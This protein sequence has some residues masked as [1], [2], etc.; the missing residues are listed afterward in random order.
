MDGDPQLWGTGP[1]PVETC[2]IIVVNPA[3]GRYGSVMAEVRTG[4]RRDPMRLRVEGLA[5]DQMA[6]TLG[7]FIPLIVKAHYV[8]APTL[9]RHF[10]AVHNALGL[11]GRQ[12]K[13]TGA[14]QR[15]RRIAP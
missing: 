14:G 1:G 7:Y 5:A 15:N 12:V 4:M 8:N 9:R 6:S 3:E 11:S 13:I 2:T 10:W